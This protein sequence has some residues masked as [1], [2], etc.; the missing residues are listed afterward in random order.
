MSK[1]RKKKRI[2]LHFFS[3]VKNRPFFESQKPSKMTRNPFHLSDFWNF[4]K[5]G[6]KFLFP[7]V[8]RVNAFSEF[9]S[10][11]INQ[12]KNKLRKKNRKLERGLRIKWSTH[13]CHRYLCRRTG[14]INSDQW[15]DLKIPTRLGG[16]FVVKSVFYHYFMVI[17]GQFFWFFGLFFDTFLSFNFC[18]R[19]RR[20]LESL[21]S[22]FGGWVP[23]YTLIVQGEA[24]KSS[25]IRRINVIKRSLLTGPEI[26]FL[27]LAHIFMI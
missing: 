8:L 27:H 23:N 3:C 22:R 20:T 26:K 5:I 24:P 25:T 17:F 12:R 11:K 10:A 7:M 2:F 1:S 14:P 21:W 4:S 18:S 9:L 19:W 13:L 6:E 16:R 15:K